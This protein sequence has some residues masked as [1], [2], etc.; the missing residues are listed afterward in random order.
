MSG[1]M[2]GGGGACRHAAYGR[3]EVVL[4]MT[5]RH[6]QQAAV[7][8]TRRVAMKAGLGVVLSALSLPELRR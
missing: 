5:T 4:I 1:F 6:R 3:I 8:V 7:N 2:V